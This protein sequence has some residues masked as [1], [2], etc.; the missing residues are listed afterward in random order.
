MIG[1]YASGSA[2]GKAPPY[3]GD[4]GVRAI[5]DQIAKS[6]HWTPEIDKG[7]VIALASGHTQITLEPG[8]QLELHVVVAW[9]DFPERAEGGFEDH[10]MVLRLCEPAVD[11]ITTEACH[12]DILGDDWHVAPRK[13]RGMKTLKN[14]QACSLPKRL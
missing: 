1:V 8:G 12:R 2:T 14:M 3:G 4:R 6:G 7:Q 9:S 10:P 5:L 13:R 11:N